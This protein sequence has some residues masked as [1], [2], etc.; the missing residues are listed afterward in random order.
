MMY[1][2]YKC[3]VNDLNDENGMYKERTRYMFPYAGFA[4][5]VTYGDIFVAF[6]QYPEDAKVLSKYFC[7]NSQLLNEYTGELR[8]LFC[9]ANINEV[10]DEESFVEPEYKLVINVFKA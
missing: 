2:T 10:S 5:N 9:I 7:L 4:N 8:F 1:Y 3:I 6:E